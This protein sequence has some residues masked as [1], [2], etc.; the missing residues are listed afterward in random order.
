VIAAP[1]RNIGEVVPAR[2]RGALVSFN[3][4]AITSG[5]LA[6]YLVDYGLASSEAREVL[7]R[8]RDEGGIDAEIAEVRAEFATASAACPAGRAMRT[9]RCRTSS[10]AGGGQRQ[11]RSDPAIGRDLEF[12][13][14]DVAQPQAVRR[15]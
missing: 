4:L 11:D 13:A 6:S 2:V 10:C 8:V 15:P 14:R 12:T 7:R 5:I 1:S 9:W 3:Q